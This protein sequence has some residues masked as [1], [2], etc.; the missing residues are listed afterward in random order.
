M[1]ERTLVYGLG[2]DA[3]A[4]LSIYPFS[5]V[6]PSSIFAGFEFDFGATVAT[7]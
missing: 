3:D 4:T 7:M 6:V 1:K 5:S 2:T